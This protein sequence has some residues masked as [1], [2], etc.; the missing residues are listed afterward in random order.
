VGLLAQVAEGDRAAFKAL[1]GA[2][3]GRLLAILVRMIGRRDV[4][5]D[6]LQDAFL[7]IWQKAKLY[8]PS[9]GAPMAWMTT[10]TRRKAIDR[11]RLVW[12]EVP[13]SES[14]VATLERAPDVS[15]SAPDIAVSVAMS[16]ALETL[17]EDY[18]KAVTL[19]Y[20]YGYTNEELAEALDIPLGTAKSRVRRGLLQLKAV[21]E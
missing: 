17:S 19:T 9:L 3:S 10:L 4:A 6:V 18:R 16:R 2:A 15:P 5:E 14:D 1:Y 11:L 21:L 8:S 12:R 13:G 20:L 7:T